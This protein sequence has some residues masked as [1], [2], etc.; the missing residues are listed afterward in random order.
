MPRT[1]ARRR[2]PGQPGRITEAPVRARLLEAFAAGCS[3]EASCHQAG[4][5]PATFYNWANRAIAE[6]DRLANV[7]TPDIPHPRPHAEEWQYVEFLE[8]VSRVRAERQERMLGIVDKVARGGS[9]ISEREEF[10]STG[11]HI[12]TKTYSQPDWRAAAWWLERAFPG[13]FGKQVTQH[14]E[15]TGQG[16]APIEVHGAT[17]IAALADRLAQSFA[18]QAEERA[19]LPPGAGDRPTSTDP[20][21]LP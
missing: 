2:R 1:N 3:V 4:I 19:R 5:A 11:A 9:V 15:V 6:L 7:A 12:V 14:H 20:H 10:T 8:A 13:Q 21:A 18:L 16:G 17:A